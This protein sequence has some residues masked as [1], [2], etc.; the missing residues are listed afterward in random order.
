MTPE[1]IYLLKANVGIA[2]FYAFYKLFCQRDTFFQW[3]RIALLS[4]LGMSFV[5]PLLNIQHWVKE[6]PSMYELAT[7]YATFMDEGENISAP[8]TATSEIPGILIICYYLYLI[9]VVVLSI[10]FLVQ[11]LSILRMRWIGKAT[12]LN[13]Q[14]IISLPCYVSPFSFFQWIFIHL[15]MLDKESQH[16]ILMHEK[17]HAKQWHS[18]DV[19]ISEII[20]IVCW[21]NPFMWLLKSEIRLNLEYLADNKV[22]ETSID[23]KQYQYHLLGLTHISK[24]TGLYNNFNVSHL[25]RRIIMM[26]KKR[27]RTAG[28]IKYALF[29]PLAAALL[30]VSNIEA[31]ARTVEKVMD[32]SE[33]TNTV[34]QD[35]PK[36]DQI[37][38]ICEVPP[39]FP[40]GVV[41]WMKFLSA[42]MKYPAEA[43]EKKQ[44]G[45]VIVQFIVEKDGSITNAK[46][47]RGVSPL[48]DQEA[49]RVVGIMPKWNP[50]TQRG[51]A[52]R[53]QYTLPV[54]FSLNGKI[55]EMQ[56][57]QVNMK[58][59]EKGI[60]NLVEEPASFPGGMANCLKFLSE[61]VK[62]PEDCKKEGIQGRVIAQF[63]IDKDGSI[64]DV[65]IVRGVHPSLDKESIRV[66]E[67]MPK[68]TP[69]KVKG[70]PVK[71][72]YTLPIAFKI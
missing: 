65:K 46:V 19:I 41:E 10:R 27:T 60:Y 58:P 36:E 32:A 35:K 38:Q 56:Q 63:I 17:T 15:P 6:Q 49:L 64:K 69:G 66:I 24:Q 26:N 55:D 43:K 18:V 16:E 67:S 5:Y 33:A 62:Y 11:L 25:K 20:N 68:W 59:N 71:C 1:W 13:G 9:G 48:L 8:V 2:L 12:T 47:V 42:N 40:G 52:V 30:L 50:A 70:E 31:V 22:V 53:V 29:A 34:P 4:F 57:H 44:E 51:Q 23:H 72:Q 61:N 14:R 37:F 3:R 7:Y 39:Q 54:M 28:R 45:R 21:F